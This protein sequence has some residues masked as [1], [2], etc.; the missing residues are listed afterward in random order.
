MFYILCILSRKSFEQN[1]SNFPV[2]FHKLSILIPCKNQRFS[3]KIQYM[4]DSA[5]FT[6]CM[7]HL[8]SSNSLWLPLTPATASDYLWLQQQPLTLNFAFL[9]DFDWSITNDFILS[10][11]LDG[12]AR[13]W[14]PASGQCLRV[15][16]DSHSC[17]LTACRFQPVNNNML[18]VSS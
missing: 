3:S 13:V 5:E 7:I 2:M 1:K 6:F 14:N 4:I 11:S 16:N 8:Y 12:T 10:A 18:L 15:V 9:L 17:G